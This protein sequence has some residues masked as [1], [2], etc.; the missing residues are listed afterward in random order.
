MIK[1]YVPLLEHMPYIITSRYPEKRSIFA[2]PF[3]FC[4]I[5]V[6]IKFTANGDAHASN[7]VQREETHV[8]NYDSEEARQNAAKHRGP[9]GGTAGWHARTMLEGAAGRGTWREAALK[10]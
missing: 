6:L 4:S 7:H 1:Y 2:K 9:I 10:F 5:F 3:I 8:A